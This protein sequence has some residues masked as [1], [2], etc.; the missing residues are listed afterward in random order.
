MPDTT[1]TD[2]PE[3]EIRPFSEFL[4]EQDRGHTHDVLSRRLHELISAVQETGKGGSL[5]LKIDVKPIPGTG[6]KTLTVT[7]AVA[8][9]IPAAERPK[10]IFFVTN[11]GNLTRNDP[12][13]PVITGLREVEPIAPTQIRKVN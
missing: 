3:T 8:A 11:D 4:R 9:K 1:A 10:S 6:A 13:Q 12:T 2:Q 5:T 7:D